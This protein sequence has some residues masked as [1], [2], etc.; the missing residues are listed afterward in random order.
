MALLEATATEKS[1]YTITLSGWADAAGTAVTPDSLTWTLT[2]LSGAVVNSRTAVAITPAEPTVILL[3]GN[4][5]AY[6]SGELASRPVVRVLTVE[7][8]YTSSLGS[9]LPLKQEYRFEV[10]PLVAVS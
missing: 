8:V 1:S 6:L 5:L 2:T 4:D 3:S 10:H 7:G 9:N